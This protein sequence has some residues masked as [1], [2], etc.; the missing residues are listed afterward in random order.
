MAV[1]TIGIGTNREQ[2]VV[3]TIREPITGDV[4]DL[5]TDA[6]SSWAAK[7]LAH[8]L[9]EVTGKALSLARERAYAQ[10]WQDAKAKRKRE[11]WFSPYW[12]E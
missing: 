7:L 12:G 6:G 4:F 8:A 3:I 5:S 2:R 9:R 10:G 1:V 11:T